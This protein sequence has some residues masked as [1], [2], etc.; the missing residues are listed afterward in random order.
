M[1]NTEV[2]AD[3]LRWTRFVAI[4]EGIS[5]LALFF[6][7]MPLKYWAEMGL[8]NQIVGMAHGFLFILYVVMIFWVGLRCKWSFFRLLLALAASLLPF[9][10]FYVERKWLK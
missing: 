3:F 10:T 6:V 7:T 2:S 8:P 5:Y 1:Q 9:A 4:A